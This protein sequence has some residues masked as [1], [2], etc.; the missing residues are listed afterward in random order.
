MD[1]SFLTNQTTEE[2]LKVLEKFMEETLEKENK[3]KARLK[4]ESDYWQA[5]AEMPC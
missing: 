3:E 2:R 4:R 5:L 1:K